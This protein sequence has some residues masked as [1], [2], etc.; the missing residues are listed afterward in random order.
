MEALAT[1]YRPRVFNDV[2]CQ[3]NV[4]RVLGNQLQTREFKQAYLFCG[5]AGTGKTTLVQ[6]LM[7]PDDFLYDAK[8][9]KNIDGRIGYV[10]QFEKSEKENINEIEEVL[11]VNV[12]DTYRKIEDIEIISDKMES[13]GYN[14]GYL[15]I[16]YN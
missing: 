11:I 1:K 6:L 14:L 5:S 4:K 10:S 15:N 16:Q 3:D 8:I 2:V 12:P 9:K 7:N 13:E